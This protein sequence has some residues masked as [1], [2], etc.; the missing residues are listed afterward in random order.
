MRKSAVY[1]VLALLLAPLLATPAGAI[2]IGER[3]LLFTVTVV[4]TGPEGEVTRRAMS[5]LTL[6]GSRADLSAGWRLPIPVTT[7]EPAE[8]GDS[9][10]SISYQDVGFLAWIDGRILGRDDVYAKGRV[11]ISAP[12][13]G[14]LVSGQAA[15]PAIASFEQ[16]FDVILANGAEATMGEAPRPDGGSVKL[17]LAVEIQP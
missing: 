6:N 17:L 15:A 12:E 16:K 10:T 11:E 5:V 14:R 4:D 9:I 3:N 1:A 2:E 8:T 7:M 13:P